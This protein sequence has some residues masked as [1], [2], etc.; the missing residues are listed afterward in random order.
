MGRR[1]DII[2]ADHIGAHLR[3]IRRDKGKSLTE[4]ANSSG[5]SK[6]YLSGIE[7]GDF[8][9]SQEVIMAYER[10]LGFQVGELDSILNE[11]RNVVENLVND[12]SEKNFTSDS[13]KN[14]SNALLL[15]I[16]QNNVSG[17]NQGSLQKKPFNETRLRKPDYFI[18]RNEDLTWLLERLRSGGGTGIAA[19]HGI[20]GIGKTSLAA[21]AVR[22]LRKEGYFPDGIAVIECE[23]LKSA[24]KVLHQVFSLF[25]PYFSESLET[26]LI[27]FWDILYR[28]FDKKKVL[29]VLDDIQP[30]LASDLGQLVLPLREANVALLMTSRQMLPYTVVPIEATRT[31]DLLSWEEALELFVHLLG[32][33][34]VEHLS[35]SDR[36][37][38]ERII[39]VL[40]RHTLAIELAGIY[41]FRKPFDLDKLAHDLERPDG[42]FLLPKDEKP[43]ALKYLLKRSLETL[44]DEAQQLFTA[45]STFASTD[46]SLNATLAIAEGLHL[47]MPE[48]QL[49]RL[50]FRNLVNAFVNRDMPQNVSDRD[51]LRIH[52]V[53]HALAISEFEN[54]SEE[55]RQVAFHA[56]A[57]YY[58]DYSHRVQVLDPEEIVTT[59]EPDAANITDSLKWAHE[60]GQDRLVIAICSIMQYFWGNRGHT[61]AS[62]NYLPWGIEAA[63]AI[64]ET[65]VKSSEALRLAELF[66][67]FGNALQQTNWTESDEA[68]KNLE[69]ARYNYERSLQIARQIRDPELEG[70][71]LYYSGRL[72]RKLGDLEK[73]EN[74]YLEALPLLR[75]VNNLRDEGW[76]LAFLG[77]I[78]EDQG[79]LEEAKGL[80]KRAL[81]LHN[82]IGYQRGA[83]WSQGF[84]GRLALNLGQIDEAKASYDRYLMI[85]KQLKDLRS[86]GVCYSFFGEIALIEREY[87]KAEKFLHEALDIMQ[88]ICDVQSQ[89]WINNLL[90][91]I[92]LARNEFDRAEMYLHQALTKLHAVKDLRGE[93]LVRSQL[94]TLYEKQGN[95]DISERYHYESLDLSNKLNDIRIIATTHLELGFFLI[96]Q[97]GNRDEGCTLISSAIQFSEKLKWPGKEE[98]WEKARALVHECQ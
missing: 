85:A 26:D 82:K 61:D 43:Q 17:T 60:H 58:A 59:L 44:P 68:R 52:S 56:L 81:A 30:E 93:S 77:Q 41:V 32:K 1:D 78:R 83:G 20:G 74:L 86:I 5:Y 39:S 38:A 12:G 35:E 46:F 84:L 87:E 16:D 19:L 55:K 45:L 96:K 6:G 72:A 37:A 11:A 28:L 48:A 80:Y 29:I 25:D 7:H 21:L 18:G 63:N 36:E 75:E 34:D 71:A 92:S 95:L 22:E 62:L 69:K 88:K 3:N 24:P 67:S 98:T 23:N 70:M 13:D 65:V 73:A 54:W 90:G 4:L 76:T 40:D 53:I 49:D 8:K 64:G 15:D 14:P 27:D 33:Q 47:Q 89:G 10:E 31:I 2:N 97:R 94:A 50:V 42:V 9:P 51:R 79:N 66:L 57:N 91:Q